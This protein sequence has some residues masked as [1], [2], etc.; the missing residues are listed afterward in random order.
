MRCSPW[1]YA[2]YRFYKLKGGIL[3]E[4]AVVIVENGCIVIYKSDDRLKLEKEVIRAKKSGFPYAIII[5]RD[6]NTTV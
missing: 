2:G 5:P 6:T 1:A 3:V 4:C